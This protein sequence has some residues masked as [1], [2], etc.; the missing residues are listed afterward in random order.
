MDRE[1]D[2]WH[3]DKWILSFFVCLGLPPLFSMLKICFDFSIHRSKVK[4]TS[5]VDFIFFIFLFPAQIPTSWPYF[6]FSPEQPNLKTSYIKNIRWQWWKQRNAKIFFMSISLFAQPP[7]PWSSKR[8]SGDQVCFLFLFF[9][10]LSCDVKLDP[11]PE[12]HRCIL[13]WHHQEPLPWAQSTG[14][15]FTPL[16]I[17][18][19]LFH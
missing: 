11:R 4:L 18:M 16:G 19:H 17:S 6:L 7:P 13:T 12:Y 9:L 8:W 1:A 10:Q 5:K 2:R 3:T 14:E 15:S